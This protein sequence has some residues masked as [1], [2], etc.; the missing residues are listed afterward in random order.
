MRSP[1]SL[2]ERALPARR[3]STARIGGWLLLA[4]ILAGC[5]G[6]EPVAP[7]SPITDPAALYMSLTLDHGA[8]NLSTAAPYN[9]LQLTA[10]PR[11][12]NG[13]PMS[14]LP[15]STFRSSDTTT[16]WVTPE[17]LLQARKPGNGVKVI[18]EL[19]A[20]GNV[21]HADT[22]MVNVT[23]NQTPPPLDVFSLEAAD[24]FSLEPAGDSVVWSMVPIPG[25]TYGQLFFLFASGR[26]FQPAITVKALDPD[27]N[28]IPGLSIE[29][30]SLD[31]EVVHVD[32]VRGKIGLLQPGEARLVARTTAYG[33]TRADTT[34]FTVTLPL[35]NGVLIQPGPNGG[36]P[37]VT[38]KSMVIRPGGYVFWTN[39]TP[40]SLRVTF[41]NP[42]SAERIEEL[43]TA[44]GDAYPAHCESGN[45]RPFMS[46]ANSP[47]DNTR[48]RQFKEP[49]SYTFH[50]EPLGITGR[51]VVTE[52]LP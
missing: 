30:E 26:S 28:P 6:L 42:A 19:L 48:G 8:I 45:I 24:G 15:A 11:D 41:D 39:Q 5:G 37:T 49:G 36:P 23:S 27:G 31:P 13:S 7:Y 32:P 10:T 18:A 47:F 43:C 46:D 4:T 44:L 34:L 17:G 25:S 20:D 16:V 9:E 1:L 12:A 51:V 38:S 50:I 29:Y 52:T 3:S 2:A 21:R 35:I 40:D 33:V 22:A 14:G